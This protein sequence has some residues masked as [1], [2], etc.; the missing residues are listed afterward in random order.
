M[1]VTLMSIATLSGCVSNPGHHNGKNEGM[2][3]EQLTLTQKQ[4]V[5]SNSYPSQFKEWLNSQF[6]QEI[7]GQIKNS[8]RMQDAAFL[9]VNLKDQEISTSTNKLNQYVR[10]ELS[11]QL[12]NHPGLNVIWNPVNEPWQHHRSLKQLNCEKVNTPNVLLGLDIQKSPFEDE[13][14]DISIR[15][16][17][18]E[19]NSW[20]SG[21]GKSWKV[22]ADARYRNGLEGSISDE[23]LK[24][25]RPLPFEENET[26]LL[27]SYLAKNTSC[28]FQDSSNEDPVTV[29]I[30]KERIRHFYRLA[31][32]FEQADNYIN[33]LQEVRVTENKDTADVILRQEIH[34]INNGL[35]QLW[36]KAVRVADNSRLSG[37]DT[38]AYINLKPKQY[39]ITMPDKNWQ[40]GEIGLM[41]ESRG[42]RVTLSLSK[43]GAYTTL[44]KPDPYGQT[45]SM[46]LPEEL[47]GKLIFQKD[48]IEGA[49]SAIA[50]WQSPNGERILRLN[51][52]AKSS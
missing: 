9:V 13:I 23:S 39:L 25:L 14:L 41:S 18:L 20:I 31:K 34:S 19:E 3:E 44:L 47:G 33:Q 24:G 45:W 5:M 51:S 52:M 22:A 15:A 7:V 37:I 32:V 42:I 50:T 2:K 1:A 11:Q 49:T 38:S 21:F 40:I 28:L 29:Y 6:T 4:L 35:Y 48:V 16:L 10:K 36:V 8:P 12:L 30:E 43:G 17:D 27:A 26:D 46:Q